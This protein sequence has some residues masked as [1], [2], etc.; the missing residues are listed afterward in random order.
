MAQCFEEG[1]A[2]GYAATLC[3]KENIMPKE[4]DVKEVR[5]FMI[6]NGSKL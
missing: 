3:V 2:G 1:F 5:R 6:D 4:V